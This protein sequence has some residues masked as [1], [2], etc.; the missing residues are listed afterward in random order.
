MK[1]VNK[2]SRSSYKIQFIP[3]S[4]KGNKNEMHILVMA[5]W[6]EMPHM[7]ICPK[8]EVGVFM[9][10]TDLVKFTIEGDVLKLL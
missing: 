5:E 8:E 4:R 6:S 7:D 1:N 3:K 10:V 9:K 2:P